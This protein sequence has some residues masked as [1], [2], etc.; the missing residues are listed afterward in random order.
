[1]NIKIKLLHHHSKAPR[2][3][4]P[5]DAGMDCFASSSAVLEWRGTV[6]VPLG[7]AVEIPDGYE[8][9]LRP[10]SG[11]ARDANVVCVFGTVDSGYRG[12]VCAILLNHSDTKHHVFIGDRV[13]QAVLA[14]VVRAELEEVDE[15]APSERG[16][17]GFGSTGR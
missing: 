1:M 11:L 17:S 13:C 8:L 15:L 6:T 14:P 3:A 2:Y 4:K 9:Q 7:F 12:E 16:E 10:R 5:G